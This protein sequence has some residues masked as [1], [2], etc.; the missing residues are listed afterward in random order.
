MF[1]VFSS[2]VI[3]MSIVGMEHKG[4][5]SALA[6]LLPEMIY[7]TTQYC[8]LQSIGRFRQ[9]CKQ[10][11]KLD[12]AHMM[13]YSHGELDHKCSSMTLSNLEEKESYDECL[14]ALTVCAL[15]ENERMFDCLYN[16]HPITFFSA[17]EKGKVAIAKFLIAKKDANVNQ[18]G[19]VKGKYIYFSIEEEFSPLFVASAG[20]HVEIVQLLI[21]NNVQIL[22]HGRLAQWVC[23]HGHIEVVEFLQKLNLID[24]HQY[25]FYRSMGEEVNGFERLCSTLSE[26]GEGKKKLNSFLNK[27]S[28]A[29]RNRAA[30]EKCTDIVLTVLCVGYL[31]YY[32]YN[33]SS[34]G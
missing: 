9:V 5:E 17:C 18:V 11:S 25:C 33:K 10:F 31:G 8:N 15:A 27:M 34:Q 19:D 28:F 24:I 4:Q 29:D 12:A 6:L 26:T 3:C 13:C 30:I 16:V 32:F 14:R 20:G 23:K 21:E 7:K 1:F 22:H 2:M